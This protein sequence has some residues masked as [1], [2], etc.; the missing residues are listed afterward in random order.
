MMKNVQHHCFPIGLS[1]CVC[2]CLRVRLRVCVCVCMC[3]YVCTVCVCVYT[4][5][6]VCLSMKDLCHSMYSSIFYSEHTCTTQYA[7]CC[8]LSQHR[9]FSGVTFLFVCNTCSR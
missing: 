6:C 1:V 9:D 8:A 2:V 4:C 7:T 3:E 5:L